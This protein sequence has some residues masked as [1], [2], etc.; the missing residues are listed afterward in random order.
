MA[1]TKEIT[2]VNGP[3]QD[4]TV[5]QA[6]LKYLNDGYTIVFMAHEKRRVEYVDPNDPDYSK[7]QFQTNSGDTVLVTYLARQ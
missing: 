6:I 4:P 1:K 3:W 2:E 5:K 7:K